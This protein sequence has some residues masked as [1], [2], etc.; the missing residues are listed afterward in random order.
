MRI[1]TRLVF[2]L[3]CGS[4]SLSASA[5]S[6]SD[7]GRSV[8][9]APLTRIPAAA[10]G[11][12]VIVI[13]SAEIVRSTAQTF[14]ELL[15]ARRPGV[16]V[17]RSGGMASDGALVLLRGPTSA[18]GASEPILII[19]GVR[20]DS[21]QYDVLL[22]GPTQPSRLDDLAPEDIERVEVL[23]GPAAALY[24]D[25]AASGVI[26]VT[27]KSGGDGSLRLSGRATMDEH[28]TRNDFPANYKRLGPTGFDVWNP[29][30]QA[31]PFHTG[32]SAGGRLELRGQTLGTSIFAGV[33]LQRR[34]GT[35]PHDDGSRFGLRTK[36]D[37][38][39][40]LHLDIEASGGY[41]LDHAHLGSG[42]LSS[43][44]FGTA[45]NDANHGYESFSIV[46][47]SLSPDQLLHH[48]TGEV[49]LHWQ[50]LAW[51]DASAL[52]GRD[53]VTEHGTMPLAGI[54]AGPPPQPFLFGESAGYEENALTT[55]GARIAASYP[56]PHDIRTTTEFSWERE[57]LRFVNGDTM[58]SFQ[59]PMSLTVSQ[60]R[61][62]STSFR[63]G[64]GVM[65]SNRLA[66]SAELQR[67]TSN[68]FGASAGKEWFPSA[69]VSWAAPLQLHGL[70][71]LRLR[72]AYA[73][74]A[75]TL[76]L[77]LPFIAD[78]IPISS[79]GSSPAPRFERTKELEVGVDATLWKASSVSL[80]AFRSRS[81]DLWVTLPPNCYLCGFF[82]ASQSA[83]MTNS[84]A[85][86][87]VSAPLLDGSR[88]GWRATLS[89][90]VLHNE[91]TRLTIAPQYT[92]N[93]PIVQ[94]YP[95]GSLWGVP[96]TYA[97]ANH[98]GIIASNEVQL[99]TFGYIG[100][101]LPTFE[102]VLTTD[103]RLP[104]RVSVSATLDYRTGYRVWNY[105]EA[106]R[107]A[108]RQC[109]GTEDPTA[110][111]DV[112]A[113]AVA[114]QLAP[115]AA[116]YYQDGSFAKLREV[117]LRWMIPASV[118]GVIGARADLTIAGRNLAT[119]TKYRGLDP[120]VSYQPPYILPRQELAD[121][122]LPREFIV[123]LD[124]S[125]H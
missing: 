97:D 68:L 73:E 2:L 16:R 108:D 48:A 70:S 121:L 26:L 9:I 96:Y 66:A 69:N 118:T 32:N 99:G 20:A 14:S 107:C 58:T 19:D 115:D 65:L 21:R 78:F 25:G 33:S 35:L 116:G 79:A 100:P 1:A 12:N 43:G 109:R 93:D 82:P 95:F 83:E 92:K 111:L 102:S 6:P 27:T 60:L 84:G 114:N 59:G 112:Q 98:D 50:P 24:G 37:R 51:L 122:P 52:T 125:R 61:S 41:L 76:P 120:E 42:I 53:R 64:E 113:A 36:V 22:G 23:D 88:F 40:P 63:V 44:L 29:L 104:G 7:S 13:D 3:L 45:E 38:Q 31:S 106:L 54:T 89:M 18:V 67:I 87:L 103:V 74:A 49:R 81:V 55:T 123:R 75:G 72:A 8:P 80:T 62:R 91:V 56:L 11:A 101:P 77:S 15:Q 46:A 71:D 119:W 4:V 85:E 86:A 39:L 34:E 5:Q 10:W 90:A 57:V 47:D 110:P 17:F 105:T 30:E 28:E 94:G 117:A 124:L